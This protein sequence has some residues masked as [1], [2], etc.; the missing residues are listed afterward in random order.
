NK[1]RGGIY[2]IE[3]FHHNYQDK[4]K[5]NNMRPILKELIDEI[6]LTNEVKDISF[7]PNIVFITK[8]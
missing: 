6:Y 3:D 5:D 4:H 1:N 2:I 7:H 8:A